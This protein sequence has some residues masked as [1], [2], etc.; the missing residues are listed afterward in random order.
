MQ[1][2]DGISL[3]LILQPLQGS[4]KVICCHIQLLAIRLLTHTGFKGGNMLPKR[5][6][7]G[8]ATQVLYQ[9][10]AP[11]AQLLCK[12]RK[13]FWSL[14]TLMKWHFPGVNAK[15]LNQAFCIRK[16][17]FDMQLESTGTQQ[18]RV[19]G[20]WAVRSSHY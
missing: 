18:C 4:K 16:W 7:R 17:Y 15:D 13:K 12:R 8:F 9:G 14:S 19:D 5:F 11:T 20:V 6:H 2:H 10:A 3:Q 1:L